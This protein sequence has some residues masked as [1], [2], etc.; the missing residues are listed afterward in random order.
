MMMIVAIIALSLW[1]KFQIE[2]RRSRF[3]QLV[4][5]YYDQ[6]M[7]ASAFSYSGPGGAVMERLLK[8]YEVRR[9]AASAYYTELIQKY[10]RA[11]RY[12]WLP[13]A[14]DPPK[15]RGI[16]DNRILVK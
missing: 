15:P 1:A 2:A 16:D 7:V 3:S 4:R 12:P 10:E 6:R 11:A 8:A 14:P 13:V 9:A 5:Q